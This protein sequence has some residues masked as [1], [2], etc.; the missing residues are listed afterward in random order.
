MKNEYSNQKDRKGFTNYRY[1]LGN[2]YFYY[3]LVIHLLIFVMMSMV[4]KKRFQYNP[5][6]NQQ[7][8][9]LNKPNLIFLNKPDLFL[10]T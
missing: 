2:I 10:K 4:N 6:L 9:L 3:G 8:I 7:F 5:S 1:I